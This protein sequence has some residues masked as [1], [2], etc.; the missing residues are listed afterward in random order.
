MDGF[1]SMEDPCLEVNG[2][3]LFEGLDLAAIGVP[4]EVMEKKLAIMKIG[5]C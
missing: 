5:E 4:W 2:E 3:H 1:E